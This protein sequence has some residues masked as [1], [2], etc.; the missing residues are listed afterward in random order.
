MKRPSH[1]HNHCTELYRTRFIAAMNRYILMVPDR[2]TST[3]HFV[4]ADGSHT[5]KNKVK[6]EQRKLTFA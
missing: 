5:D 6:K 1:T 3:T 2:W 4:L